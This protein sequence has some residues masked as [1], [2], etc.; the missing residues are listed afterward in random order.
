MAVIN[1]IKERKLVN[2][3]YFFCYNINLADYL[4]D[5]E[6]QVVTKARAISSDKVFWMFERSDE[7]D[8]AINEY[9]RQKKSKVA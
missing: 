2:D 6:I 4:M 8:V 1:D 3:K 5:N 7:L 9:K